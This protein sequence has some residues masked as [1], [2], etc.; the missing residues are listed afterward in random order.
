MGGDPRNV[1]PRNNFLVWILK[2]SGC[3]STDAFGG[4]NILE[5][6]PLLG[7]LPASLSEGGRSGT[8][9]ESATAKPESVDNIYIIYIYIYIHIHIIHMHTYTS[10]HIIC[11]WLH[12]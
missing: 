11:I 9:P 6:R 3:H 8:G 5:C 12:M 1:A 2:P 10:T 4:T 7:A